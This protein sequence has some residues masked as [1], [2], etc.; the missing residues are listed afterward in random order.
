[1]GKPKKAWKTYEEA[2]AH[3]LS[4]LADR[5][6]IKDVEGKQSIP[7]LQTGTTWEIDAKATRVGDD[8][9]VIVEC[10]RKTTS[11]LSQEALAAIAFR[12]I[13]TGAGA[14][15]TVSPF[16][17]QKGAA[18]VAKAQK[19]TPI[20][21]RPESTRHQWIAELSGI[22]HLGFTDEFSAKITDSLKITVKDAK[23]G[24]VVQEVIA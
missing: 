3:M 19:I 4:Q 6:G 2:A 14:A 9:I 22:L 11:R 24:K 23:T 8:A 16:P 17:L 7:G 20:I 10:R 13:D 5:L 1:M 15:I 12:I 21:L 18:L